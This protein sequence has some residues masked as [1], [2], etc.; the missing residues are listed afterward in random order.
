MKFSPVALP[1]N[2]FSFK[3]INRVMLHFLFPKGKSLT[4]IISTVVSSLISELSHLL[5]FN[6]VLFF[7]SSETLCGID[8]NVTC[9]NI[10]YSTLAW[11]GSGKHG[12]ILENNMRIFM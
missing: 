5:Y 4:Y 3:D 8:H 7:S 12:T 11:Q 6:S 1:E 10:T 2:F 9:I